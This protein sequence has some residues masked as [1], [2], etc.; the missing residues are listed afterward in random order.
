MQR[1][2]EAVKKLRAA[3]ARHRKG[4]LLKEQKPIDAA[5]HALEEIVEVIG[6]LSYKES[7]DRVTEEIGDVFGCLVCLSEQLDISLDTIVE[8]EVQKLEERYNMNLRPS[9]NKIKLDKELKFE[10]NAAECLKC[11]RILVSEHVH[12]FQTCPCGVSVDGGPSYL[13]RSWPGG[14]PTKWFR[15]IHTKA[16]LVRIIGQSLERQEQ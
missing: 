14:D 3:N 16:K 2:V 4:F 10:V 1:L 7:K 12:D 15:D 13:K 9:E 11:G 5:R 6:A 8:R